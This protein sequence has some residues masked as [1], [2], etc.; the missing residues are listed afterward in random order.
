MLWCWCLSFNCVALFLSV[1]IILKNPII[2]YWLIF[3]VFQWKKHIWVHLLQASS[4]RL[5]HLVFLTLDIQMIFIVVGDQA[6]LSE[7]KSWVWFNKLS[8]FQWNTVFSVSCTHWTL[9]YFTETAVEQIIHLLSQRIWSL[10]IVHRI[11]T[12]PL[13]SPKMPANLKSKLVTFSHVDLS[14]MF[15]PRLCSPLIISRWIFCFNFGHRSSA[16]SIYW[17]FFSFRRKLESSPVPGIETAA[18]FLNFF[19]LLKSCVRFVL[20]L[21]RNCASTIVY[22]LHPFSVNDRTKWIYSMRVVSF[23]YVEFNRDGQ[24]ISLLIL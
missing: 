10:L 3:A 6:L 11:T 22:R 16:N 2:H 17:L 8:S 24:L 14:Y 5:F 18:T 7:L 21:R 15:V 20:R 23:I 9:T 1:S 4:D 19:F 13:V 12:R